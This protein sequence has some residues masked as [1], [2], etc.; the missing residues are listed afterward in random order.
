MKLQ[1][2]RKKKKEKKKKKNRYGYTA[3]ETLGNFI[4]SLFLILC[5]SDYPRLHGAV[6]EQH[7]CHSHR[8]LTDRITIFRVPFADSTFRGK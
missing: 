3:K 5:G 7:I 6:D 1:K 2:K 4:L 8:H